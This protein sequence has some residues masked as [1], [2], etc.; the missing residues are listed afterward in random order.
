MPYPRLL[1]LLNLVLLMLFLSGCGQSED[2]REFEREARSAPQGFTETNERG[3]IIDGNEDPNDWRVAPFYQGIINVFPAYPNPVLTNDRV[4]IEVQITGIDAVSG[5]HV[6]VYYGMYLKPLDAQT[7]DLF[8]LIS[9]S[10]NPLDIAERPEAPQGLYR[11]IIMDS[12]SNVITYGDVK[13]Q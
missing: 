12:Q 13:V 9:F 11:I 6:Y 4:I 8:G 2:Q 1:F 3:E 5:I 10:L 7:G